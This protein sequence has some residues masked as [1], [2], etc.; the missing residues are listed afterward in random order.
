DD[1][2]DDDAPAWIVNAKAYLLTVSDDQR[3]KRA[4]RHWARFEKGMGYPDGQSHDS[5]LPAKH[6]PIQVGQWLKA[7]KYDHMPMIPS[8]KLTQYGATWRLWWM[9]IQPPTR[10]RPGPSGPSLNTLPRTELSN[11]AWEVLKR[12]GPNGLF[13]PLIS[14]G[15]WIKAA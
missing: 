14:L 10:P 12:G 9:D 4:V 15:W 13:I 1:D 3:W 8:S 7:R 11:G 2:D 6:R 5:C